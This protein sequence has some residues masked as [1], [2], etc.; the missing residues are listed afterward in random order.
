MLKTHFSLYFKSQV[1]VDFTVPDEIPQ[2]QT[3]HK[4]GETP[5]KAEIKR[6]ISSMANDK[7]PGKTG[8][9]TDKI[10]NLP[11]KALDFYVELI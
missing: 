6:A 10:K 1:K 5:S 11:P 3:Q 7:A 8:L 4:L 9:T 2:H